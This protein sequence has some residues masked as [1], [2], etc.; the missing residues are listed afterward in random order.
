MSAL[1]WVLTHADISFAKVAIFVQ[2]LVLVVEVCL[3]V[4]CGC[5]LWPS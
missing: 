4:S 2:K 3:S 1:W 5:L